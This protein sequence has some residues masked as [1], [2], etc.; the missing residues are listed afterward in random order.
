MRAPTVHVE[1]LSAGP[2][3]LLDLCARL[4][5]RYPVLLDSAARGSL[6]TMSMLSALPRCCLGLDSRGAV[7]VSGDLPAV[8]GD[9][10]LP[11]L[12]AQWRNAASGAAPRPASLPFAGGWFVYLGYEL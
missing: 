6:S 8:Q 1:Q 3:A 2:Q 9:A 7:H 5:E 12:D 4:P 10:F 11:A